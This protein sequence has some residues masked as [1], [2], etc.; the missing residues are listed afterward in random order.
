[1]RVTRRAG[2][3]LAALGP[4]AGALAARPP[5]APPPP[6]PV[7]RAGGFG[8]GYFPNV[9]L[10]T[11]EDDAVRFYDD[12]LKDKNVIINML[13]TNCPDGLCPLITANLVAVQRE[14]G[15]RVGQ[16]IFMYSITLDPLADTQRVL[17]QYAARLHVGQGWRFLTGQPA[18]IELLRR[19]LGF[20]DID[21]VLDADP[22]QH[23]GVVRY[24]NVP[25]ER[26]GMV[27]GGANPKFIASLIQSAL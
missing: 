11:H 1:M 18:D 26:W 21:P 19:K 9:M 2:L 7:L 22:S 6:Q 10:R 15:A 24:G 25:L 13:L 27:A 12:L 23:S 5:E 3:A 14:L 20:A 8:E 4:V 17:L 16:D